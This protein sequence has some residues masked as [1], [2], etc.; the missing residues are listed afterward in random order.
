[1]IENWYNLFFHFFSA[2]TKGYPNKNVTSENTELKQA[3]LKLNTTFVLQR[4]FCHLC[5]NILYYWM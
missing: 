3:M 5:C 4:R 2:Q 1:L